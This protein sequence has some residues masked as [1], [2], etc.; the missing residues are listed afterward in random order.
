MFNSRAVHWR[1]FI[2]SYINPHFSFDCA[3]AHSSMQHK[4]CNFTCGP[5]LSLLLFL[6]SLVAKFSAH[7]CVD[8]FQNWKKMRHV[9]C[10]YA[11]TLYDN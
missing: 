11:E 5:F 4:D 9:C 6:P 10:F 3:V 1:S 7:C 2:H 8:G